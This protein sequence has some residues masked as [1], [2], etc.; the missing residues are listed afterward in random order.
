MNHQQSYSTINID[1]PKG[2]EDVDTNMGLNIVRASGDCTVPDGCVLDRV[3]GATYQGN[4]PEMNE[5]ESGEVSD[6]NLGTFDFPSG[7]H[8]AACDASGTASNSVKFWCVFRNTST[9]VETTASATGTYL[10]KC[11]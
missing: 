9:T 7:L 3:F 10:G 8:G 2:T 1:H 4:P 6:P 11:I 5:A